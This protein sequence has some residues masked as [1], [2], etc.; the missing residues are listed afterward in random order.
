[1]LPVVEPG[2][3]NIL[4]LGGDSRDLESFERTDTMIILSVN[5]EVTSPIV[6][7]EQHTPPPFRHPL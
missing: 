7:E 4:L 1:E 5:R 6:G 3:W 2:W